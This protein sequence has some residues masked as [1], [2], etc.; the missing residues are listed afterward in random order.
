MD[1][2]II[3]DLVTNIGIPF[4]LLGAFAY[5]IG[6][7]A[8][9][10]SLAAIEKLSDD[11]REEMALERTF[12]SD[13]IKELFATNDR[14]CTRIEAAMNAGHDKIEDAINRKAQ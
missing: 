3:I 7:V 6:K 1:S 9:P 4:S 5:W 12:H 14:Q 11:F 8:F 2:K 10:K 13:N